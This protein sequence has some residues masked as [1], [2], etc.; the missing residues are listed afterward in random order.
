MAGGVFP[1]ASGARNAGSGLRGAP[2]FQAGPGAAAT[3]AR[4]GVATVPADCDGGSV[5]GLDAWVE[6]VVVVVVVV[7]PA[8]AAA[9]ATGCDGLL[10]RGADILFMTS[11]AIAAATSATPAKARS[12]GSGLRLWA[13]AGAA[14]GVGACEGVAVGTGPVSL[15]RSLGSEGAE[16]AAAML[17]DELAGSSEGGR[18][19]GT[20]P[21]RLGV[22]GSGGS[23][24]YDG[25]AWLTFGG[26]ID[27]VKRTD[28]SSMIPAA[29][30][31]VVARSAQMRARRG[32]NGIS[33]T[34]SSATFW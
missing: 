12:S 30:R 8:A 25:G 20:S 26:G 11:T 16:R 14:E 29:E 17:T 4:A 31:A 9:V 24:E 18:K 34:A 28:D 23:E 19:T 32:A 6:T 15:R 3:G 2:G 21:L 33:A 13:G 22:R 27:V 7:T 5:T 10:A 1:F